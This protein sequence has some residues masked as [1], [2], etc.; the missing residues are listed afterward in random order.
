MGP[1]SNI[2]KIFMRSKDIILICGAIYT[3]AAWGFGIVGLPPRVLASEQAIISLS[4][5]TDEIDR[6]VQALKQ[7]SIYIKEGLDRLEK[8]QQTFADKIIAAIYKE[9]ND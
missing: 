9:R 6:Q 8:A 1:Q 5:K 2:D 4:K 3:F 7:N